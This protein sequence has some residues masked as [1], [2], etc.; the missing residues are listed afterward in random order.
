MK[1]DY[2]YIKRILTALR[3]NKS[4][5]TMSADLARNLGIDLKNDDVSFDKFVGH[6][7]ILG[8]ECCIESPEMNFGFSQGIDGRWSF[9]SVSYRLTNRGYEFL[10]LLS[11]K[12]VFNKIK[13]FSLSAA[14]EVGK[15]LLIEA[16]TRGVSV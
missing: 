11:E 12:S 4:H 15:P 3:D 13:D 2:E 10:D 6:I 1:L 14:W 7:R 5:I 16:I 9:G 8:D